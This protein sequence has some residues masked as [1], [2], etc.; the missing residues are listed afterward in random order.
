MTIQAQALTTFKGLG[1]H[2]GTNL[3]SHHDVQ[4][5]H[6]VLPDTK[7]GVGDVPNVHVAGRTTRSSKIELPNSNMSGHP[8]LSSEG[9]CELLVYI[10]K[11]P[12]PMLD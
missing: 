5:L 4:H 11:C 7:H 9:T 6:S 12:S 3:G 1:S 2:V 8:K 10:V